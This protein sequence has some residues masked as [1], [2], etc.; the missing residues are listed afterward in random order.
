MPH[1]GEIDIARKPRHAR[2]CG[3]WERESFNGR[4]MVCKVERCLQ[5]K[6]FVVPPCMRWT[7]QK[8]PAVRSSSMGVDQR[9]LKESALRSGMSKNPI[10]EQR[11]HLL[12]IRGFGK[13]VVG[14]WKNFQAFRA[15]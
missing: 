4:M 2:F 10:G 15:G 12:K 13:S 8:A 9:R 7:R 11:Q 6:T 14:A 1:I 3:R 5:E